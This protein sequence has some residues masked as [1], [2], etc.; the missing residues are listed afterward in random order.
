MKLPLI[1]IRPLLRAPFVAPPRSG[2][3]AKKGP[4][5]TFLVLPLLL[6]IA[7]VGPAH[8][9]DEGLSDYISAI[10]PRAGTT[11]KTGSAAFRGRS[12][13]VTTGS[14]YYEGRDHWLNT[15]SMWYGPEGRS[16]MKVGNQFFREDGT[17]VLKVGNY[18]YRPDGFSMDLDTITI[19][20][21]DE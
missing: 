11:V 10:E 8:A 21:P 16:V 18:Y 14:N 7:V 19:D 2:L 13:V 3:G 5:G 12:M 17:T 15:G 1:L 4:L 6:L 20:S 9:D